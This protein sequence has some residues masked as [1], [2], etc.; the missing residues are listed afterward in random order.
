MNYIQERRKNGGLQANLR[1]LKR[2]CAFVGLGFLGWT[3]INMIQFGFSVPTYMWDTL[4]SIGMAGV[5][6]MA[7]S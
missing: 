7:L 3:P 1:F 2:Y 5:V 4:Q 6:A